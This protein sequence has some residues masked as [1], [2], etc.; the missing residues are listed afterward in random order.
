MSSSFTTACCNIEF[1]A[2]EL[3]CQV[4]RPRVMIFSFMPA[5]YVVEFYDHVP[6]CRVSWPR[7]KSDES[8]GH[9]IKCRVFWSSSKNDE[10][11][12]H[13]IKMSSQLVT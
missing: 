1:Y 12:G 5:S 9:V 13:V 6:G 10:S 3:C 4:L 2:R 11:A 8:A 7:A